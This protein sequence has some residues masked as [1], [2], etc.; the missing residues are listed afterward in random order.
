[1]SLLSI[2]LQA[3]VAVYEKSSVSAAA[4]KLGVGQTAITQ[5]I[6]SLERE[7]GITL[8]TR[9]RKGMALT[10]E[11]QSL[12][13]YC[14][15]S[16]ELEGET[17]AELNKGGIENDIELTIAGPTSFISGRAVHQCAE[18]YKKWPKLN[19]RFMINDQENRIDLIK[20]GLA[21]IVVLYPH[22]VPLELDSKMI[23]PDEYILVG[24]PSWKDR[25]L[26][27]ILEKERIFAFHPEDQTSLNYLKSFDLLKFLKRPRLF[28]NENLALSSLLCYGVGFGILSKEIAKPFLEDQSLI[29]LNQGRTI[30]DPLALAWYP[31][32]EMP[33]YLKEIVRSIK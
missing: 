25:D 24:H 31:R 19:I 3:F 27:D 5:R 7:L 33:I 26:K 29:K 21:D 23:K 12:L 4:D 9:S 10:I 18:I 2:N 20:Q 22:Q 15:R 16:S 8:F 17:F 14:L 32:V 28:V 30:K 6:K 11:G 1:M 13:K